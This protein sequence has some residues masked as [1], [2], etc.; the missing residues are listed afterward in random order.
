[1]KLP[2]WEEFRDSAAEIISGNLERNVTGEEL[3]FLR[4]KFVK[5]QYESKLYEKMQGEYYS[6]IADIK[7]KSPD[8]I[9]DSA[10]Q[11]VNKKDILDYLAG[12]SPS[13][14]E[15]QYAALLSSTNTLDEIYETW[16][17]N[18]EFHALYDIGLA[19]E[20]TADDMQYSIDRRQE[21]QAKKHEQTESKG[22]PAPEVQ[23]KPKKHSL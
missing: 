10:Y 4:E 9:V 15:K 11:I 16:C 6:F 14:S 2:D 22:A 19:M 23:Q 20:E 5:S 18:S 12:Q 21:E 7:K 1:M 13:L 3:A 17:T 8:E